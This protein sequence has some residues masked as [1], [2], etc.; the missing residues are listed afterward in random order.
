MKHLIGFSSASVPKATWRE[1]G[2]VSDSELSGF[3]RMGFSAQLACI[4]YKSDTAF[5]QC[6]N[7][8]LNAKQCPTCQFQDVARVYTVGDFTCYPHMYG[9]CQKETYVLYLAQFGSDLTKLG[10]TREFRMETRWKEQGADFAAPLLQ[11]D[12]PDDAYKAETLL[13]HTFD[14]A[15]SVMMRQKITRLKFDRQ[16]AEARLSGILERVKSNPAFAPHLYGD[17]RVHDLSKHYPKVE[18]PE[19][20]DFIG[21]E[22]LGTKSDWLF[23]EG[24][25]GQH[26]ASNMRRQIGRFATEPE[27]TLAG[28]Y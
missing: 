19:I 12:G 20:V 27:A 5:H 8:A 25:S 3:L 9:E 15:N 1:S 24:P 23:F 11:F 22:I 17:A 2:T 21:G 26:Y 6:P 28:T 14:L 7:R 4:G 16:K 13:Q 10:L 18:N